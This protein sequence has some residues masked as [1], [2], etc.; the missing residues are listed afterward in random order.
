M[1]LEGLAGDDRG[2]LALETSISLTGGAEEREL[3]ARALARP[4]TKV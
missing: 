1:D 3:L 2:S 4:G